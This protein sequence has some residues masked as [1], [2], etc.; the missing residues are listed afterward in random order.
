MHYQRWQKY[1]DA[2]ELARRKA[3][4][5]AGTLTPQGYRQI[6]ANGHPNSRAHGVMFEHVAVMSKMLGRPLLP[7]ENV[8]HRNG[9]R[10]DNR[11][12]N[13][14]LWVTSQPR[15]QR[16]ADLLEWAYRVIALYGDQANSTNP[17]LGNDPRGSAL[18]T[19]ASHLN[20]PSKSESGDIR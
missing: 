15:G 7:N 10:H 20:A 11:P 2:G 17:Q 18:G 3:P 9:I 13:L 12:E 16:P 19:E 8:H 14:E 5:G 1:G 4:A 6:Q